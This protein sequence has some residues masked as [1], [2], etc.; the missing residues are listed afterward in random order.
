MSEPDVKHFK[1]LLD[2]QA[3]ELAQ[4]IETQDAASEDAPIEAGQ[5][6]TSPAEA[7]QAQAMA[8]A[9]EQ[10]RERELARIQ[11]AMERIDAGTYGECALCGQRIQDERLESDP[12]APMCIAC[13]SAA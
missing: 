11:A 2:E 9:I 1:T 5:E 10:R 13:A 12:A 6:G 4:A 8:Q 3:A 7:M